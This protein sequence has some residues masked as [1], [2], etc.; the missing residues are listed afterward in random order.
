MATFKTVKGRV[1]KHERHKTA[2]R[3]QINPITSNS[4]TG[5]ESYPV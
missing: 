1:E 3:F 5:H 2:R 4:E